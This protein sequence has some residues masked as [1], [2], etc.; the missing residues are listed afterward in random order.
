MTSNLLDKVGGGGKVAL[1]C[2][3]CLGCGNWHAKS[4]LAVHL[5]SIYFFM[6]LTIICFKKCY[7]SGVSDL[8]PSGS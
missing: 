1:T 3:F 6:N 7:I 2:I 4:H 8:I 5:T